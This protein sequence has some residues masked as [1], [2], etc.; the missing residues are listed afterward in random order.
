MMSDCFLGIKL[1][2]HWGEKGGE[3]QARDEQ[4]VSGKYAC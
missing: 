4:T 3:T 1:A 2:W